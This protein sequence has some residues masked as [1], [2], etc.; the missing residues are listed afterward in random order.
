M[1]Q[2]SGNLWQ[3]PSIIV[4]QWVTL[5]KNDYRSYYLEMNVNHHDVAVV[6]DTLYPDTKEIDDGS[7]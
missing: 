3:P 7:T 4:F 6:S 2:L 1:I 5:S